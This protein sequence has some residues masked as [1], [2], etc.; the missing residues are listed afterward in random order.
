MA[1]TTPPKAAP[2]P[3]FDTEVA[4]RLRDPFE[5]SPASN[6]GCGLKRYEKNWPCTCNKPGFTRQ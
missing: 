5:V 1:K 3:E 4:N 6:G 2:A